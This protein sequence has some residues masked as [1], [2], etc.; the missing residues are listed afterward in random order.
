MSKKKDQN[1]WG[2][3]PNAA[4]FD[5]RLCDEAKLVLMAFASYADADAVCYPGLDTIGDRLDMSLRT[6]QRHVKDAT[7]CG[8]LEYLGKKTTPKGHYVKHW[9]LLYP[10]PEASPKIIRGLVARSKNRKGKTSPG[11]AFV[12]PNHEEKTSP[13]DVF[14]PENASPGDMEKRH[15]ESEKA[16][17]GDASLLEVAHLRSSPSEVAQFT[18]RQAAPSEDDDIP[19]GD[20]YGW[21]GNSDEAA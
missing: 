12:A 9:R 17:P 16:S 7:D 19:L 8:Y 2:R 14:T 18:A 4:T 20:D 21:E 3:M 5:P 13:G 6:V 1:R 11:D 10:D 15:D